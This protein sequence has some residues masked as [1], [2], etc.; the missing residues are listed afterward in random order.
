[1]TKQNLFYT[2]SKLPFAT[3]GSKRW[4]V[5]IQH[6]TKRCLVGGWFIVLPMGTNWFSWWYKVD[7]THHL[8]SNSIWI[9]QI[10]AAHEKA[11]FEVWQT[12]CLLPTLH[13]VSCCLSPCHDQ[14]KK[15]NRLDY[16][17]VMG[18]SLCFLFCCCCFFFFLHLLPGTLR[19]PPLL[20]LVTLFYRWASLP[21]N[22]K[23]SRF[24]IYFSCVIS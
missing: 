21:A 2:I 1:M 3:V 6:T 19:L 8:T 7:P 20:C 13:C 9:E 10:Q 12:F 17:Q 18:V 23:S 11:L 16:Y 14:V 4:Y 5:S 24:W 15:V 22:T